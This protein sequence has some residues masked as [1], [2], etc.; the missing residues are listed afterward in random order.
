M[1]PLCD[2]I[3]Y[4]PLIFFVGDLADAGEGGRRKVASR[5]YLGNV[6][7]GKMLAYDLCRRIPYYKIIVAKFGVAPLRDHP[8][9]YRSLSA[10][11]VEAKRRD[12][13]I[14]AVF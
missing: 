11:V 8:L 7:L 6:G 13:N 1:K 2:I 9:L 4:Q 12:E 5:A 14:K 10:A 3:L